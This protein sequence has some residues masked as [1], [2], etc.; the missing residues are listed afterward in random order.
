MARASRA[1]GRRGTWA[2]LALVPLAFLAVGLFWPLAEV[3]RLGLRVD[4]VWT[5]DPLKSVLGDAYVRRLLGFTLEQAFLSTLLSLALGF[6]LGWLLARYQFPG[7]AALRA[8]TLVP[9]VLP[10]ITVALG[11]FLFFGHAGYLNQFLQWA[12]GLNQPPLR[13]LYT[14]WAIVLAHAFYNAPVVARFVQAAWESQDP[15]L[16]EAARVLG[17][18]PLWAFITV[19]L[20]ALLPAVVSASALIFMLCTLS[21]A[22]PLALGGA[23]FATVE[24]GVYFFARVE[25][26]F[27]R[28]VAL[29]L[30]VLGLSLT[31]TYVYLR[32]GGVFQ[33]AQA[34]ERPQPALALFDPTRPARLLWFVYL[35]LAALLFVGPMAAVMADSFL[36]RA[37]DGS[38]PTLYWYHLALTASPA[39]VLGTSPLGA[40]LTSLTVGAASAGLALVL[41]LVVGAVLRQVR[42]RALEALLMA[43]VGVSSV[44]L[45]LALLLAFRRPPFRYLAVGPWPLVLAHT[46]LF[47][48]FVVRA[49][50]PLWESLD[51]RLVEAARTLGASRFR[52][53]V[54]VELPLLRPGILVAGALAFALSLGEMTAAAMLTRPG[55]NTIPLSIYQYLSARRFGAASAMATLLMVL[56]ALALWLWERTSVRTRSHA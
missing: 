18:K 30:V 13:V 17:A 23:Q 48:P 19:T 6:P 1:L 20:P 37:P 24:V 22:I 4:G 42:S 31:L 7:K 32:G 25:L 39:P 44:V 52:A 10:P 9:F 11:F 15:A 29:A 55:L 28:A 46:L 38:S 8:F 56:T 51:P 35:A 27:S 40:I 2:S 26:D 49:V 3:L 34:R 12:L 41:G 54:S 16:V 53:F 50:Q 43:P 33:A 47:Y 21:F 36:R 5:L 14:L 45:G